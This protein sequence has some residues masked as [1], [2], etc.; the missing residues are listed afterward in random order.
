MQKSTSKQISFLKKISDLSINRYSFSQELASL[1]DISLDSAY[2]RIRGETRLSID[3]II[4]ICSHYNISFDEFN[5]INQGTVTFRFVS[6]LG[7]AQKLSKEEQFNIY[8]DYLQSILEDLKYLQQEKNSNIIYAATDIPLFHLFKYPK[9]TIFKNFMWLIL[10][11]KNIDQKISFDQFK[12]PTS[13]QKVMENISETYNSI[14]SIE[15][16]SSNTTET[17]INYIELYYDSGYFQHKNDAIALLSEYETLLSAISNSMDA[18]GTTQKR[19][20]E[21]YLSDTKI[22]NDLILGKQLNNEFSYIRFHI[23][24]SLRTMNPIFCNEVN[25][26]LENLIESSALVS[27]I[28]KKQRFQ[29]FKKAQV[30]INQVKKRILADI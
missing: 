30:K 20:F 23:V 12:F 26:F 18:S 24:N 21:L 1:L 29:F 19:T 10:Q 17:L 2:R 6:L 5:N 7:T 25:I 11:E 16:W 22:E 3:E 27:G 8:A 14:P 9:L 15:I 4:L 13:I 28:A